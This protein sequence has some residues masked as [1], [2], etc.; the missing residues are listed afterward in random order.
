M[1][2]DGALRVFV[3]VGYAPLLLICALQ[4]LAMCF[5]TPVN[6]VAAFVFSF[7]VWFTLYWVLVAF[8]LL[9]RE[10][11]YDWMFVALIPLPLFAFCTVSSVFWL[12]API[13]SRADDRRLVRWGW[14]LLIAHALHLLS[15]IGDQ[16][17]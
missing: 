5:L 1:T 6:R 4:C 9:T 10:H 8:T 2:A 17:E 13:E 11:V 14:V 16:L 12:G 15:L 3:D 7:S